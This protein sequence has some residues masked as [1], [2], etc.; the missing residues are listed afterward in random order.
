MLCIA[1][2]SFQTTL[3]NDRDELSAQSSPFEGLRRRLTPETQNPPRKFQPGIFWAPRSRKGSLVSTINTYAYFN[4]SPFPFISSRHRKWGG[5]T[6]V[7]V[8]CSLLP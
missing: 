3:S 8:G 6:R 1:P 2:N 5:V 4:F 7:A